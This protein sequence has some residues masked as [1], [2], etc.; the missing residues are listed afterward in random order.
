MSAKE[1]FEPFDMTPIEEHKRK[2]AKEARQKYGKSIMDNVE[3][4]TNSYSPQDWADIMEQ[5]S[6]IYSKIVAT[7]DKGPED[8]Q[9][10]EGVAELRAWITSHFYD[11]TPEIFHGLGDLYVEDERFTANI[12]KPCTFIAINWRANNTILWIIKLASAKG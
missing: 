9:V 2:Y 10:Q 4:K 11:C 1:R 7:M 3:R 5:S 12:D 8:P 6:R